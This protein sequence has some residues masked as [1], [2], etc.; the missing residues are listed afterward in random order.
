MGTDTPTGWLCNISRKQIN[1][2][3]TMAHILRTTYT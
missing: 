2:K 3:K 1:K